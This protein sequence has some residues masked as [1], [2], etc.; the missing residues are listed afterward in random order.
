MRKFQKQQILEIIQSLHILHGKIRDRLN[1]KD[2]EIVQ[3]A[4]ADKRT[5]F[6]I[7]EK[8]TEKLVYISYFI[9]GEISSSDKQAV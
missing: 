2:Y 3:A 5:S 6:L 1:G 4:L 9:S 8:F 7:C